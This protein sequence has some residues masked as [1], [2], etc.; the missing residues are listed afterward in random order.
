[1]HVVQGVEWWLATGCVRDGV[2]MEEQRPW[3]RLF[4]LSWADFFRGL[5]VSVETEKDLS[6]KK[7]L[8]D[9]I[10]IRK[11]PGDLP[12]RLP[13]GFEELA[14]YNLISFIAP[15]DVR[16]ALPTKVGLTGRR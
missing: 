9:V 11:E 1:M 14:D 7:Q 13:D 6:V 5:P 10:L 8:L 3:H 2:G 16:M 4:G 15:C 12:C